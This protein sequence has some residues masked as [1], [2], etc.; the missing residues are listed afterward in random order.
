MKPTGLALAMAL[1]AAAMPAAAQQPAQPAQAEIVIKLSKAEQQA[2]APLQKAVLAKDWAAAAAA[3]PAAQ[4]GATS[5]GARY[6]VARYALETGIATNDE[7]AQAAAID[8]MIASGH[9]TAPAELLPLHRNAASFA[10]KAGDKA[11]EQAMLARIVELSPQDGQARVNLAVAKSKGGDKQGAI[12]LFQSAIDVQT[13]AGAKADERWYKFALQMALDEKLGPQSLKLSRD[14]LQAYPTDENRRIAL[15]VN[16]QF[17]SGGDASSRLNALQTVIA[18]DSAP[19]AWRQAVATYAR[20]SAAGADRQARIDTLRLMRA[21]K[22][23]KGE[24]NWLF[25]ANELDR[26]GLP[27]EAKAVLE[28]GAQLREVSS[29][30]ADYAAILRS[31]NERIAEDRASLAGLEGRA[32]SAPNGTAALKLADAYLGYGEHAKAASLYRTALQKGSI[33]ADV[34][35]LRLGMALALSGQRAEAETALKAVGGSRTELAALW[36]LWLA[37]NGG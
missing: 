4:A 13:A 27:G 10:A 22:T 15:Q 23:L 14:L 32:N 31:A 1:A 33:D 19:D 24:N 30:N 17:A 20:A 26:T 37:N 8:A 28:E 11:K 7:K 36:L 29:G 12:E 5:T 25:L 21:T 2:I 18:S 16:S 9:L 3:M 6:M 35:R 34:A